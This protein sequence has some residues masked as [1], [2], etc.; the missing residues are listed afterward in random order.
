MSARPVRALLWD[1]DG[2][3]VDSEPLHARALAGAL[4]TRG[5]S[6]PPDLHDRTLGLSARDL[7]DVLR[8]ETTL[9]LP[10]DEWIRLKHRVYRRLVAGLRPFQGALDCYRRMQAA[11]IR[12]AIVSN[13]DRIIVTAN[14]DAAGLTEPGLVSV[15]LN[16]VRHGKPDPEPYLRAAWLL[17]AAP[18]E[19]VV[20]EDSATGAAAGLAAGMRT[21]LV[22]HA[23]DRARDDAPGAVT[24]LEGFDALVPG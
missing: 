18:A 23:G 2:T 17:E 3:L 11:G 16:D 7:Y 9:D 19:C 21:H 13:S 8:A 22:P 20:I 14:L 4:E 1:M 15:S 6:A 12:Q 5:L 10:F 24:R